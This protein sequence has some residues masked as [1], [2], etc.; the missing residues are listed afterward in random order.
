[1]SEV[2]VGGG[3]QASGCPLLLAGWP[4]WGAVAQ[5]TCK[6]RP[7]VGN[8]TNESGGHL[9]ASSVGTGRMLVGLNKET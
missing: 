3:G 4:V 5:G 2:A 6:Q 1:M 8:L 9:Q 7:I